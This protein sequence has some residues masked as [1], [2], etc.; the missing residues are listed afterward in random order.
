MQTMNNTKVIALYCICLFFGI[1]IFGLFGVNIE[2]AVIDG[3]TYALSNL[4]SGHFFY[5][6]RLDGAGTYSGYGSAI[7]CIAGLKIGF[8]TFKQV[9]VKRL[10]LLTEQQVVNVFPKFKL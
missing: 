6:F 9:V 5:P 8:E 2:V 7:G 3:S 4:K 1:A 10:S